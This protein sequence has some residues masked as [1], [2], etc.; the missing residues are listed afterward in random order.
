MA[1]RCCRLPCA[2]RSRIW[3]AFCLRPAFN[4]LRASLFSILRA[5]NQAVGLLD[6]EGEV[7]VDLDIWGSLWVILLLMHLHFSLRD[8]LV[9]A[10]NGVF[11]RMGCAGGRSFSFP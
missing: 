5:E 4:R 9:P 1:A 10:L 11:S 3:S 8:L 6:L 7:V 2:A